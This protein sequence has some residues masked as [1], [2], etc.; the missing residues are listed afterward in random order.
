MSATAIEAILEAATG[1]E[2]FGRTGT[3]LRARG[4][5]IVAAGI[6][7]RPHELAL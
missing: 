4:E 5:F 6:N 2:V 3:V 7:L 1:A